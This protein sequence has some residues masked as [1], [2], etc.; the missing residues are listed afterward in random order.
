MVRD[1][2]GLDECG[3]RKEKGV[4][5]QKEVTTASGPQRDAVRRAPKGVRW[6]LQL[7]VIGASNETVPATGEEAQ[8]Q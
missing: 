4:V 1:I 7:E 8:F 3:V 6:I 5:P 2:Q